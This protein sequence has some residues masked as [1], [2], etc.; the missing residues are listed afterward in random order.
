MEYFSFQ[1]QVLFFQSKKKS[2]TKTEAGIDS[3]CIMSNWNFKYKCGDK[4]WCCWF[5]T[6]NYLLF[7]ALADQNQIEV[8]ILL[9]A[10]CCPVATSS[11][12]VLTCGLERFSCLQSNLNIISE[13][14]SSLKEVGHVPRETV[15]AEPTLVPNFCGFSSVK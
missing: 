11:L 13:K 8:K 2:N 12:H 6:E 5:K 4:K 9:P 1:V 3:R 7:P 14:E 10:L 15:N